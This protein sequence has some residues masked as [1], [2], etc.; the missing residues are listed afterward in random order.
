MRC[1][2]YGEE[3]VGYLLTTVYVMVL[4]YLLGDTADSFFCPTL[5]SVVSTL[6]M[7]P[8]LAGV[9]FLSFGNGAPDVFA[10][11][12]AVGSGSSNLALGALIGAS[13]FVTTIV[14]AGVVFAAP[15]SRLERECTCG[16]TNALTM[17]RISGNDLILNV[18]VSSVKPSPFSVIFV[19]TFSRVA[20]FCT[21]CTRGPS[22]C[23]ML[24]VFSSSTAHLLSSACFRTGILLMHMKTRMRWSVKSK[25]NRPLQAF[26]SM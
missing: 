25:Q 13:V 20:T 6:K 9:T 12:A 23:L 5:Q 7:S 18:D 11:V 22:L 10:S 24:S 14:V 15:D 19:F 26:C 3:W 1:S 16:S 4:L 21:S 17:Q 2:F 8:T